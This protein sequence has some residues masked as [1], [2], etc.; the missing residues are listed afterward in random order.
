MGSKH[1]TSDEVQVV[2]RY[3]V[4][5]VEGPFFPD[6]EFDTLSASLAMKPMP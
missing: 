2:G 5:A 6:W 3:I 4:A 1:L